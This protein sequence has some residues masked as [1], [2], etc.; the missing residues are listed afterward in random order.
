MYEGQYQNSQKHGKG[1]FTWADGSSYTGSF[2]NNEINGYGNIPQLTLIYL[3]FTFIGVYIWS[4][5]KRYEGQWKNHKM[6]G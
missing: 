4:N 2:Q 1:K 5:K 3:I 6:E